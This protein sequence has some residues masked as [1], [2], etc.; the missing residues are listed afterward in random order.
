MKRFSTQQV[1]LS[2]SRTAKR[3]LCVAIASAFMCVSTPVISELKALNDYELSGV[4]GQAGLTI[5]VETQYTIGEFEYRDAGSMYTKDISFTGIG[6]GYVDN[7]RARVDFTDGN[8]TLLAGFADMAMLADLGYLDSTETDVAWAIGEYADGTGEFGKQLG[9]GDGFI[10]ISSLDY[11]LDFLS[12]ADPADWASNLDATKN[13]IDLHYQESEFGIR[14]SD[15][16]VETALSR[17]LSIEAYLGYADIHIT[18]RGNGYSDTDSRGEPLG[19]KIGDS[20][21][22][23]DVKFRVEDLD[24]DDTNNAT[25]TFISRNVTQPGLTL[26]DF[27]IHNE[28]GADTLGSFGYASVEQKWGAASDII[29]V[30][31][32]NRINDPSQQF[33][34]GMAIYDINVKWD[35]DLP[36]ISFG[37]TGV[38]IGQVFLTDF[39]IYDTSVVISAH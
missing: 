10:H 9:D 35:W 31:E 26:R 37:D 1:S 38:S 25:N 19:I 12:P 6:G 3:P 14:S 8:E 30:I 33:V 22:G 11:G 21:I 5:D 23:F 36:H 39:Q 20:Y 13:A 4:R 17:N 2:R 32:A 29:N 34:D 15:G 27:R 24:I 7:I 28:R 16:S 18:N